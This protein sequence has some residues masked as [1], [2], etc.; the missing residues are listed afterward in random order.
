MAGMD[1]VLISGTVD[2]G[3]GRPGLGILAVCMDCRSDVLDGVDPTGPPGQPG[4]T[5]QDITQA[6]EAHQCAERTGG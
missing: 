2:A 3:A 5:G 1:R 4:Y 6:A